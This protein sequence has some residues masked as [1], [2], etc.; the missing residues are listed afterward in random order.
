MLN[1]QNYIRINGYSGFVSSHLNF[2]YEFYH[3]TE[4][5]D[6]DS[7]HG[8]ED[9]FVEE[10]VEY[11]G[12]G[13]DNALVP[14][15]TDANLQTRGKNHFVDDRMLSC[16]DFA[17][18]STPAAIHLISATA[19]ALGHDVSKLV[20]NKTSVHRMRK[21]FRARQAQDMLDNYDVI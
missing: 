12:N 15:S 3:P 8:E 17:N 13:D 9:E 5:D 11:S 14:E 18:M 20:L 16:M 19:A 4:A 1:A 21:T 10:A 7:D 6:S 2:N